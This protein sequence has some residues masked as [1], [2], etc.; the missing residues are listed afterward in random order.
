MPKDTILQGTKL[1]RTKLKNIY[2]NTKMSK[3]DKK[4]ED[5]NHRA[6]DSN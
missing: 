6:I 3:F 2:K 5:I 4:Q 1:Q